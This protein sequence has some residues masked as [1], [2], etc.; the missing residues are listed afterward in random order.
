MNRIIAAVKKIRIDR[1]LLAFV[2]GVLLVLNTA[3][4]G[5]VQAK[6][7]RPGAPNTPDT[8]VQVTGDR[9]N[10]PAGRIGVPGKPNPRP[11]VPDDAKTNKDFQRSTMNE[12]SDI[13]PGTKGVDEAN[14]KAKALIENAEQNVIDQTSNVGENTQRILD[15]K[16]ENVEDFGKNLKRSA[17]K[18]SEEAQENARGF[19]QGTRQ[20][21]ENIKENTA[22]A[23]KGA[24]QATEDAKQGAERAADRAGRAAENAID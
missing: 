24:K 4:S 21:T 20:G 23:I 19:S 10:V 9:Q 17:E 13:Q 2:A 15:K 14:R 16:G 22:D 11:E 8:G 12:F 1:M 18:V 6:S 3:C 7:P 5:S